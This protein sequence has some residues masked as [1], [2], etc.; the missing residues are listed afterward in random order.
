MKTLLLS[1]CYVAVLF[2]M[3]TLTDYALYW[4]LNN[5][6][7]NIINRY[8]HI[9]VFWEIVIF[10]MGTSIFFSFLDLIGTGLAFINA[11]V[12]YWFPS[13][14]FTLIISILV[15]I[16][17]LSYSIK[18]LWDSIPSFTFLTTIEF[19]VLCLLVSS[20]NY[21]FVNRHKLKERVEYS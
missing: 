10:V 11:G 1:L 8:N 18:I 16:S 9:S 2:I 17:N 19:I 5:V 7:F 15:F 20:I 21:I 3:V 13:N 14:W 6:V 12:F 4:L